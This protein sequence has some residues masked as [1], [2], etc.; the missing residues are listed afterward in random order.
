M[1]ATVLGEPELEFAL[2]RHID[3]KHGLAELGPLDRGELRTIRVGIVGSATTRESV[4]RW[5]ESASEG[6]S[7]KPSPLSNLFPP[8]PGF[9]ETSPL[10][11]R[12]SI[13]DR[14]NADLSPQAI[15][16]VLRAA[17][18]A[19][20]AADLLASEARRLAD[21]G[22][23]D[24]IV[25]ATPPEILEVTDGLEL[26]IHAGEHLEAPRATI[27]EGLV[28]ANNSAAT[29]RTLTRTDL[30][31]YLKA[32]A[33]AVGVPLQLMRPESYGLRVRHPRVGRLGQARALQD[34]ATRA[35]NFFVALYYKASGTPWRLVRAES[36]LSTC[37]VGVSF[38]RSAD[39]A[40]LQ[41][42]MAQVFNERGQGMVIRGEAARQDKWDRVPHLEAADSH[43]LLKSA[44]I[45]YRAE[46]LNLPAR[47]V[48]HKSS[49]HDRGEL[50]GLTRA[51]DEAGIQVLDLLSLGETPIR[52]L[53]DGK[54]PVLRGTLLELDERDQLLYTRGSVPFFETYPG[55]YVPRPIKLRLDSVSMSP[56]FLGSEC[57]AL[58]K[59]NW[60]NTQFDG[61]L[62][63]TLRAAREV[64]RVL[65][66]V[67][68]NVPIQSSYA[69]YM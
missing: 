68:R 26:D 19:R 14:L 4:A 59:M 31:D 57:L 40:T 35:W 63:I 41:T 49:T 22:R 65:R 56:R 21:K 1:K 13:Q 47:V 12:V 53:R 10:N 5:M 39:A 11:A 48:V 69:F 15:A 33:L 2:G 9:S 52:L 61:G 62:P 32:V 42:S 30:R 6:V 60:N 44:L 29:P 55:S 64:G 20:G 24:V 38:Y 51:A 16:E 36:D 25:I 34:E 27:A 23:P 67:D 46:H 54:Y 17:D 8:F 66:Y 18:P 50:E 37:F 28:P 43:S 45:A 3:I 7:A 58:T